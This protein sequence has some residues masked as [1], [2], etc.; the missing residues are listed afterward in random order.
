MD[1]TGSTGYVVLLRGNASL[2]HLWLGRLVSNMGDWF[3]IIALFHAVQTITD[4]AQA[5]VLVL[6]LAWLLS[7]CTGSGDAIGIGNTV[8]EIDV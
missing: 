4:S 1:R 7:T 6:V 8:V 2:R 3:N 5:V